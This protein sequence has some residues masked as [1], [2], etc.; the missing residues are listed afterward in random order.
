M[1]VGRAQV[2][3]RAMAT[4]TSP[5]QNLAAIAQGNAPVLETLVQMTVDTLERS[6][7]D[8]ETY[9]LVRIAALV[10]MD[11]APAS[12]LLNI[13]L[14]GEIGVPIEK[15]QGALVAVAPVV[16]TARIVSAASKMVR[17]LGLAEALNDGE[18]TDGP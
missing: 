9:A 2:Q 14:A 11:A 15:L 18:D 10:A 13:G 5:Q 12:Y 8:P 17:A 16:G 7:L 3:T 1:T 4:E 6:G